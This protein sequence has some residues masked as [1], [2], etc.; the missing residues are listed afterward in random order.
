[1]DRVT[2]RK[3]VLETFMADVSDAEQVL[4]YATH[5]FEL[6]GHV[7]GFVNNAGIQIPVRP[8]VESRRGL[9]SGMAINIR[10]VFLRNEIRVAT[11]A[12]GWISG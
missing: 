7:D 4:G 6:W 12:R 5:A 9:R 3:S 8:I 11:H 10:G 1:M 2:L